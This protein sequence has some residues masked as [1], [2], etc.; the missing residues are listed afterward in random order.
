L[1]VLP[2]GFHPYFHC[3]KF[4]SSE[5]TV[6]LRVPEGNTRIVCTKGCEYEKAVWSDEVHR[7]MN[8]EI[9][10]KKHDGWDLYKDKWISGDTHVHWA[11]TW[12][13]L[14]DD[15]SDL[16]VIQKASDCHVISIL[17]LSQSDGYQEIFTPVHHPMGLI[18][19][20]CSKDYFMSMDE[21]Y[22]N[23]GPYG[24]MNLI[25]LKSLITPVSTGFT[26]TVNAPDYPDNQYAVEKAHGQGAIAMCAHGIGSFDKVLLAK[27]LMDCVD[28]VNTTQY[29]QVLNC[30]FRIPTTVGTDSNARP[31]GKMRTYVSISGDMCYEGWVEGIRKGRTFVTNGP[32][33]RFE[34]NGQPIGSSLDIPTGQNILIHAEAF[35]EIP[36][37]KMEIVMNGEVILTNE[38]PG[39]NKEISLQE[40]IQV[41]RSGWIALRATCG[42]DCDWMDNLPGAHTSPIYLT[43]DGK[44]MLPV[45]KDVE[46]IMLE[47]ESYKM[48]LPAHAKFDGQRQQD[49]VLA[50][51]EE[52]IAI[53]RDLL[54]TSMLK[55]RRQ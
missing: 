38:N 21:E 53:Y 49:E 19:E 22:R 37:K 15:T 27:G 44:P 29:Y 10:L 12:V 47:L 8:I 6:V 23:S 28:Q 54:R 36:L 33:L 31:M 40:S 26:R 2:A 13:Y 34:I 52:G 32:L 24:H 42:V 9:L 18:S 41:G 5:G 11:K 39:E 25:G 1:H 45:K 20:H 35:S 17:T 7:D 46:T 43:V 3:A 30:G 48:Q 14:G 55:R 4:L 50:H 16:A 51:V